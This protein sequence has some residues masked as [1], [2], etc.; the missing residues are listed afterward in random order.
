MGAGLGYNPKAK[1]LE[2]GMIQE[3]PAE[4]PEVGGED[5]VPPLPQESTTNQAYVTFNQ[6]YE[7]QQS[8]DAAKKAQEEAE[9]A[10]KAAEEAANAATANV[11]VNMGYD[12]ANYENILEALADPE[13]VQKL[14]SGLRL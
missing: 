5:S 14:V 8:K 10:A 3:T 11:A 2:E 4:V 12:F 7:E 13:F 1:A 9:A 6:A